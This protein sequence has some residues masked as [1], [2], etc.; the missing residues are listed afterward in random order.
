MSWRDA[1]EGRPQAQWCWASGTRLL[2]VMLATCVGLIAPLAAA[3]VRSFSEV[4]AA[5]RPV[6]NAVE[7]LA[8]DLVPQPAD[9]EALLALEGQVGEHW[10]L[11]LQV[12]SYHGQVAAV[13]A[14]TSGYEQRLAIPGR[15][16][17]VARAAAGD[18][19]GVW[20]LVDEAD[21]LNSTMASPVQGVIDPLV[22][23]LRQH[24]EAG[25][26]AARRLLRRHIAWLLE[27]RML[28]GLDVPTVTTAARLTLQCDGPRAMATVFDE[29]VRELDQ[30]ARQLGTP[31]LTEAL[32]LVPLRPADGLSEID[33][34]SLRVLQ[35]VCETFDSEP[36]RARAL[37]QWLLTGLVLAG[38][39][40]RAP[41]L[42]AEY[43]VD[44]ES[45][46]A[47]TMWDFDYRHD[48]SPFDDMIMAALV[49]GSW[50]VLGDRMH[51]LSGPRLVSLLWS[52][53]H[54]GPP[55]P[56][57]LMPLLAELPRLE[58]EHAAVVA[59]GMVRLLGL[60]GA[61]DDCVALADDLVASGALHPVD[62]ADVLLQ[63]VH[64]WSHAR[65]D[66]A[67]DAGWRRL[68]EAAAVAV[69][70]TPVF[71]EDASAW[72]LLCRGHRAIGLPVEDMTTIMWQL[73]RAGQQD[74]SN[75]QQALIYLA[76]IAT[77]GEELRAV[78]HHAGGSPDALDPTLRQ[79]CLLRA[80]MLGDAELVAALRTPLA[81]TEAELRR[82]DAAEIHA[83]MTVL[84]S[85]D[86][87]AALDL[88]LRWLHGG[89]GWR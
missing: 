22:Q 66:L 32:A 73:L 24:G 44:L 74:A 69:Q 78:Y 35:A 18:G 14:M 12:Q 76:S 57:W 43:L 67:T 5:H 28:V 19:E 41:D 20:R 1:A 4:P 42:L 29:L 34:A 52:A 21:L 13:D 54:L 2:T 89:V 53:Q 3:S 50:W 40:E 7:R 47:Q 70:T 64:R 15:V 82:F 8:A 25:H 6:W 63:M 30:R 26:A 11:W 27:P 87:A 75:A 51:Q 81:L 60:A 61:F 77:T 88:G 79:W 37:R 72:G 9:V 46:A 56:T 58:A 10:A 23:L 48:R 71:A 33:D 80:A 49:T 83:A 38:Q 85:H 31:L 39:A 65:H 45:S 17:L 16:D 59:V 36:G 86:P 68:L 62:R 84:E 55:Q